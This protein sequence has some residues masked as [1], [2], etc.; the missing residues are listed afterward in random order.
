MLRMNENIS[1]ESLQ[2]ASRN[3]DWTWYYDSYISIYALAFPSSYT[4]GSIVVLAIILFIVEIEK[5]ITWNF[6]PVTGNG[7]TIGL[8]YLYYICWSC[9]FIS[10]ATGVDCYYL[11]W[12][13]S[14]FNDVQN[15]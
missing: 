5:I 3:T 4:S 2:L 8:V 12:Y 6:L 9:Y 13:W 1:C 11:C 14:Y 7:A 10:V 15:S